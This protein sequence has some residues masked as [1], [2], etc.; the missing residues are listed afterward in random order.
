MTFEIQKQK[1]LMKIF[2][3]KITFVVLICLFSASCSTGLKESDVNELIES[4][5]SAIA[6]QDAEKLSEFLSDD[7]DITMNITMMGA[8][9]KM[10]LSKDEYIKSAKESWASFSDYK[11]SRSNVQITI[12]GTTAII[13]ADIKESM[14]MNFEGIDMAMSGDSSEVVTVA[15]INK[16]LIITKMF[17]N[18][19]M[20]ISPL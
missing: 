6:N 14:T 8:I 2:I 11:Y 18:T 10:S 9:Q 5:D 1:K 16:K 3:K 4:I 15:L 13:S 7:V 20:G 12:K 19:D 17:A